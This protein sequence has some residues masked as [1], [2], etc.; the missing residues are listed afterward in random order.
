MRTL[1]VISLLL[2]SSLSYAG[3]PDSVVIYDWEE[4]PDSIDSNKVKAIR[5][6]KMKLEALPE[7]LA[8]FGH[9]EYLILR[10]N[11]LSELPA[12]ITTFQK[13]KYLDLSLNRF[14]ELPEQV[15]ALSQLE[16]LIVNRNE[17]TTLPVCID[18]A[19]NL[20]YIDLWN[21]PIRTL[22]NTLT[23]LQKLDKV[24][25]SGIKFGPSFQQR[26]T[27]EMPKVTFV[28]E[29]PCDCME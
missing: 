28:F 11:R 4:I 12:F 16:E 8:K 9:I 1:F 15:C 6:S 2:L 14:A 18:Q 26:W 13:L 22:P 29:E 17:I 3:I 27:E 25:L 20:T 10:K 7:E 5:F 24:D 23:N 21:N 19:K